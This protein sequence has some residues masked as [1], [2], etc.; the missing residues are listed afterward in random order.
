MQPVVVSSKGQITIPSE[1]LQNMGI[2]TGD[3]IF[4]IEENGR[5]LIQNRPPDALTRLQDL[6]EGEAERVGWK[7]PDD[8]A[9]YMKERR[10][11]RSKKNA[12]S[13]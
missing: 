5:Y 6:M 4:F 8:I 3:K 1:V 12:N 7:T 2:S 13:A 11:I 10:K 9:N